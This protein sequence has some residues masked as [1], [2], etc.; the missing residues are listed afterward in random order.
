[1][2]FLACGGDGTAGWVLS[3]LDKFKMDPM[4]P[5]GVLPLGKKGLNHGR[6]NYKD[7]EP[8]TLAFL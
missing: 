3:T 6:M 8:Y 7:T 4:P 1:V 2:K 5:V